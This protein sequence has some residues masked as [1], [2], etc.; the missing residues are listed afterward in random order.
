MIKKAAESFGRM[1][2]DGFDAFM[3]DPLQAARK[4]EHAF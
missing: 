4:T 3:S 1:F 2:L